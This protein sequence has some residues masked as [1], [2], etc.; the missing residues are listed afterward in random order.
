[1][2]EPNRIEGMIRFG[3]GPIRFGS[4][5]FCSMATLNS[6]YDHA[7]ANALV[8]GLV[9][10]IAVAQRHDRSVFKL[11]KI[12]MSINLFNVVITTLNKSDIPDNK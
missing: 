8:F 12:N 9:W 1:M 11:K 4:V 3:E 5:R 6:S 7:D 10:T 2:S